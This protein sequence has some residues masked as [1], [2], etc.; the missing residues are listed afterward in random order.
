MVSHKIVMIDGEEPGYTTEVDKDG[1]TE[2]EKK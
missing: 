1:V 2:Y